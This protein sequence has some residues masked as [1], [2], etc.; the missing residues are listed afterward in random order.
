MLKK[1]LKYTF[2][3][4]ILVGV[5]VAAID[6]YAKHEYLNFLGRYYFDEKYYLAEYPEVKDSG[7]SA[8]DH[9]IQ[10]GWKE[11]K[12]PNAEFDTKLYR[13]LYIY[14]GNKYNLNPLSDFVYNKI[15]FKKRFISAWQLK[16][17]VPLD[18]PKYYLSLVALFRDEAHFLKEWIEFYRM[19]GVEHFYLYNHLSQD[20]YMEVLQPYI[21][22]G[23]V[24][25]QQL[26]EPFV[27]QKHFVKTQGEIYTETAK[28][29]EDLSEWLIVVDVDE[30]L[31]PVN[32]YKLTDALKVYDS[33]AALSV[34]WRM[35]GSADVQRI[36]DD[37]LMIET[38]LYKAEFSKDR[39]LVKTIVKPR[40]V[41]KYI[42]PHYARLK[43]EYYQVTENFEYF[44][45]SVIPESVEKI[46]MLNHYWAKDLDYFY[47]YKVNRVYL[48]SKESSPE[49]IK[50]QQQNLLTGNKNM[51]T[52][53]D[54]AI[55]KYVPELR[56]RVFG[57]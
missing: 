40:Y 30:F 43:K 32:E 28:K 55:L 31:F 33:Y 1:Y 49:Q 15:K 37:K 42:D 16:K 8:Y 57:K 34:N 29:T 7:L 47:Q 6:K 41:E 20:N 54:D 21:D 38:L 56:K 50:Q 13:N 2:I 44:Y 24:E 12:N 46:F 48:K 5:T 19:I 22:Q 53:Y 27:D 9:Y 45:G 11:N 18:N 26:T 25:L 35:F 3:T 39:S 14:S 4:L 23:I 10:I 52:T 36:P 51:S 17:A